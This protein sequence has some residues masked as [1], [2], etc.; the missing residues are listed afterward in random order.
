M[1]EGKYVKIGGVI[2]T[3]TG[4]YTKI[5]GAIKQG[6]INAIDVAGIKQIALAGAL[7]YSAENVNDEVYRITSAGVEDWHADYVDGKKVAVN[8]DGESYWAVET[9]VVKLN[10]DGTQAWIYTGHSATIESI[11][12]ENDSG[13]TYIYSG[14]FTGNVRRLLDGG[15]TAGLMWSVNVDITFEPP[16]YSLAV[17]A[18]GGYVYAGVGWQPLSKGVWRAAVGTGTF[19]NIYEAANDVGA[20]AVDM[21]T[22]AAVYMGDS[23]GNYRKLSAN[24]YVYWTKTLTGSIPSIEIAHNGYGY[25]TCESEKKVYKFTPSTGVAIWNY[26][27]AL[28]SYA[29]D[30]AVDA[31]G[32]VYVVFRNL[33]GIP[34]NFIYKVNKNGAFVWRYQSYVNVKFYGMAVTPG[35]E[36][37]GF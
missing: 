20:L 6:T 5:G 8:S 30:C 32:N 7:I 1:A 21:A 12:I 9:D 11:A 22:P 3:I 14:D 19:V 13:I 16:V 17:D 18:A 33:G 36:A 27:P 26:T 24:G 10:A 34:G 15:N 23:V 37:A 28:A 4:E 31:S 2:K 35:L 25:L 29:Y